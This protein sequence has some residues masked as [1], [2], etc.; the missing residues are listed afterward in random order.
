M[1]RSLFFICFLLLF[2]V[3][4]KSETKAQ[5]SVGVKIVVAGAED[6]YSYGYPEIKTSLCGSR[7]SGKSEAIKEIAEKENKAAKNAQIRFSPDGEKV[8]SFVKEESGR[9]V[10]EKKLSEDIDAALSV[11]GGAISV[12]FNAL[13]PTVTEKDLRLQTF[14]RARFSTYFI[15]SSSERIA[16]V[17]LAAKSVNGSVIES[18]ETFSFNETVGERTE[19]RGYKYAK[20]IKDG[21]FEDGLGGGV[22]QVSTTLYNAALLSG[23]E[24]AEYHP[25]TLAVSYVENSFDAMVSYGSADLKIKNNTGGKIFIAAKVDEDKITFTLFGEKNPYEITRSSVTE[26]TLPAK[27]ETVMNKEL[28]AGETRTKIKAKDG[29]VSKGYLIIR[30]GGGTYKK[31]IRSDNYK[32]VDGVIEKGALNNLDSFFTQ[33]TAISR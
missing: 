29:A 33:K 21:K 1:K 14:E 16:N 25:H 23:L 19:E 26:K 28:S 7:L 13:L 10:D 30:S 5:A 31:L 15:N 6:V 8:F 17:K 9:A 2:T 22:C 18:G 4:F 24:I 20:I 27:T 32:Q 3:C 11:G 12:T